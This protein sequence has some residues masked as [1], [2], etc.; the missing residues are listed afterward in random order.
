M[1]GDIGGIGAQRAVDLH[2]NRARRFEEIGERLAVFLVAENVGHGGDGVLKVRDD[3]RRLGEQVVDVQHWAAVHLVPRLK[4]GRA[5]AGV[6]DV[7]LGL[8]HQARADDPRLGA[9]VKR[10]PLLDH[11]GHADGKLPVGGRLDLAH[12]AAHDAVDENGRALAQ[13]LDVLEKSD[14]RILAREHRGLL[15]ID[16]HGDQNGQGRQRDESDDDFQSSMAHL[17]RS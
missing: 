8:A 1:V 15:Q 13:T 9:P 17:L 7:D 3:G 6:L 14:E 12:V 4:D 2:G 16:R 10:H 11:Q 5:G